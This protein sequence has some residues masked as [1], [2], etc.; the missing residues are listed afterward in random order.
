MLP[1]VK[2]PALPIAFM[3]HS[4]SDH[5][6]SETVQPNSQGPDHPSS[7][8][9]HRSESMTARLLNTARSMLTST[10]G[11]PTED[12]HTAFHNAFEAALTANPELK[13]DWDSLGECRVDEL[14]LDRSS[15]KKLNKFIGRVSSEQRRA[16]LEAVLTALKPSIK[17]HFTTPNENS[18]SKEQCA[19]GIK[20]FRKAWQKK[21]GDDFDRK[22]QDIQ[23][24]CCDDKITSMHSALNRFIT[25]KSMHDLEA[26]SDGKQSSKTLPCL[27]MYRHLTELSKLPQS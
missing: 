17:A 11:K 6:D 13:K 2:I 16:A 8:R 22:M 26:F 23:N 7:T 12:Q 19:E 25:D 18:I 4:D 24:F 10:E 27:A 21:A 3:P 5:S 1:P 14:R 9:P 15:M 20:N